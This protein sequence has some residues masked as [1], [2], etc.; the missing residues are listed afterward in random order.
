MRGRLSVLFGSIITYS[1]ANI[2]NG[3]VTD[4]DTYAWLRLIAGVGLAGELGA[5]ITL[6]S[7]ADERRDARL[8]PP[9]SSPAVG[10]ASV[11]H[12]RDLV[13]DAAC[14]WRTA[15]YIGGGWASRC[16]RCASAS[17]ESGDVRGGPRRARRHPRR[18]SS[19][20]SRRRSAPAAATCA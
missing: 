16:S 15:Y 1:L 9:R 12:G 13:G 10:S 14:D 18:T 6:V 11:R 19:R 7:R 5:G 8:R 17:H 3:F 2:A 4:V 20:C